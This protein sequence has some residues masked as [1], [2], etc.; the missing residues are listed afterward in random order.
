MRRA[1]DPPGLR[2]RGH[3][4]RR[5]SQQQAGDAGGLRRQ[6][7]LAAGDE[8]ELA[9]LSPDL[10][11]DGAERIAGQRVGGDPQR[12]VD[13]ISAHRHQQAGIE[14]EFGQSAHRQRA[15]FR[16]A[17]ILAHPEQ[18]PPRRRPPGKAC[19][20]TRRGSTLP[21]GCREHLVHRAERKAAPQRRIGLAMA[22]R[23]LARRI[24]LA[25]RLDALDVAAQTGKRAHACAAHA[26]LLAIWGRHRVC[27]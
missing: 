4:L 19:D 1:H 12:G 23:H 11:H 14:T 22:E 24:R 2:R 16:F 18:W 13:V 3:R 25:V 15:G 21:A 6:G 27:E 8:I 7:Q 10:E 5:G 26:P 17:E 20:K 9:R